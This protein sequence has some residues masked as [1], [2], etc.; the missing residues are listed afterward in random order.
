M[1]G[2]GDDEFEIK[3]VSQV[4]ISRSQLVSPPEGGL[5]GLSLCGESFKS[6]P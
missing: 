2:V 1:E 4:P 3:R 5:E 6:A